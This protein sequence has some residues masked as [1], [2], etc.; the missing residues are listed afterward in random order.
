MLRISSRCACENGLTQKAAVPDAGRPL[1]VRV[2]RLWSPAPGGAK[3]HEKSQAKGFSFCLAAVTLYGSFTS[4]SA[5]TVSALSAVSAVSLAAAALL[6][7]AGT[8]ENVSAA[9]RRHL[10]RV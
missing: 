10:P 6:P 5:A 4:P 1:L 7:A 8:A 9:L 2:G 3:R